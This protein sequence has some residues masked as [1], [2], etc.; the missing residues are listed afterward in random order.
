[1]N[2]GIKS[3]H[4]FGR[5]TPHFVEKSPDSNTEKVG[6]MLQLLDSRNSWISEFWILPQFAILS[7]GVRSCGTFV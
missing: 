1:M 3:G 6:S 2:E 4:S 7:P 5:D